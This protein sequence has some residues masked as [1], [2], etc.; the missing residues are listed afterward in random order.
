MHPNPKRATEEAEIENISET[1]EIN[2]DVV[3]IRYYWFSASMK[4][5]LNRC[6]IRE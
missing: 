5:H 4:K 2:I 3:K 6:K 1:K